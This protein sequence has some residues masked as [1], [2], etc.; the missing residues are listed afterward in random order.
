MLPNV[1]CAFRPD[2]QPQD[3]ISSLPPQI[4]PQPITAEVALCFGGYALC[5]GG[6][7]LCGCYLETTLLLFG[8][9]LV[10]WPTPAA[11]IRD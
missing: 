9:N 5:F 11:P 6:Y 1:A 7:A 10:N 4:F 3:H 8:T 2:P